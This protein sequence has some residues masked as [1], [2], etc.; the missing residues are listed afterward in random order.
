MFILTKIW[1]SLSVDLPFGIRMYECISNIITQDI[2]FWDLV[3]KS[4]RQTERLVTNVAR[5]DNRYVKIDQR[6]AG[7]IQI[8]FENTPWCNS[9]LWHAVCQQSTISRRQNDAIKFLS[10][11]SDWLC[12]WLLYCYY[13]DDDRDDVFAL[14]LS[15]CSPSRSMCFRV[16]VLSYPLDH[17]YQLIRNQ[18]KPD[19]W[20]TLK[21]LKYG[22]IG[23]SIK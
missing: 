13:H 11:A 12:C 19:F 1:T 21:W 6:S 2:K 14:I 18:L 5:V 7:G 15:H 3:T 23:W 16:L 20:R 8:K 4:K 9:C 17:I 22:L 10:F